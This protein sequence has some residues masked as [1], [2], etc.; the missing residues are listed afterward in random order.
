MGR[1]EW[2][3]MHAVD[4]T[5]VTTYLPMRPVSVTWN[6]KHTHTHTPPD[7][8]ST[9]VYKYLLPVSVMEV[10]PF[11]PPPPSWEQVDCSGLV[12]VPQAE[13]RLEGAGLKRRERSTLAECAHLRTVAAG[14]KQTETQHVCVRVTDTSKRCLWRATTYCVLH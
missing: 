3:G 11:P 1:V 9:L 13:E 2:W 7:V 5:Y 10:V 4:T 14:S 8:C 12:S 6:M